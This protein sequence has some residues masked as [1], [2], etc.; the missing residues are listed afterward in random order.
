MSLAKA[1]SPAVREIRILCCQT[2]PASAGTRSFIQSAYPTI[3]RHNPDLPVLIREA[4]GVPARIFARF[5]KGV[6]QHIVVDNLSPGE[7]TTKFS[8]LLGL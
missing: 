4:N 5:E 8:K 1:F 7:I 2:S 3:K 6:E